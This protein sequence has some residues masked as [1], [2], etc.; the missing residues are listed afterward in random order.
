MGILS[1]LIL[2]ILLSHDDELEVKLT[3]DWILMCVF[4][5]ILLTMLLIMLKE[6]N[7][8]VLVIYAVYLNLTAWF[9]Y[10]TGYVYE[11]VNI[12]QMLVF[13]GAAYFLGRF[14]LFMVLG[15]VMLFAFL[16]FCEK[17]NAFEAGDREFLLISYLFFSMKAAF[18]QCLEIVLLIMLLGSLIFDIFRKITNKKGDRLPYTPFLT[19]SEIIIIIFLSVL[20]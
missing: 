16:L 9:D 3:L 18:E 19:V 7:V 15:F 17:I 6:G 13:L 2:H 11:A 12:I 10:L 20:T 1:F 14:D 4:S 5:E 8:A